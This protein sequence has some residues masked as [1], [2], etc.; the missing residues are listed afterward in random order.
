M[1]DI[2]TGVRGG[3]LW[4]VVWYIVYWV[5]FDLLCMGWYLVGGGCLGDDRMRRRV[6]YYRDTFE[7]ILGNI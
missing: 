2:L 7:C 6:V 4:W 5:E 1:L 3:I